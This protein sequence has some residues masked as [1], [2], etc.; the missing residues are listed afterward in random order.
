MGGPGIVETPAIPTGRPAF[1]PAATVRGTLENPAYRDF[2][3]Q[4][5]GEQ[6]L[7]LKTEVAEGESAAVMG[8]TTPSS[9]LSIPVSR[10]MAFKALKF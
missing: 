4:T 9:F 2:L 5:R 1:L 10:L 7:I 6:A 8:S 3:N